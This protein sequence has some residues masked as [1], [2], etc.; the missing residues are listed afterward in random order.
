MCAAVLCLLVWRM[1]AHERDDVDDV[2][3]GFDDSSFLSGINDTSHLTCSGGLR[4]SS[5]S[6]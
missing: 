1:V 5:S 4:V 6:H 3:Q 2:N